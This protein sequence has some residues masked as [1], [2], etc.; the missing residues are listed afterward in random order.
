MVAGSAPAVGAP[1][2]A[3]TTNAAPAAAKP[4]AAK[5]EAARDFVARIAR[6]FLLF[7]LT[8]YRLA[9]WFGIA[10]NL[11]CADLLQTHVGSSSC[12]RAASRRFAANSRRQCPR[13]PHAMAG[14]STANLLFRSGPLLDLI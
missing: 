14:N 5:N 9:N 13:N 12:L 1:I 11:R 7:P 2:M 10:V 3:D 6:L 8:N 4:A